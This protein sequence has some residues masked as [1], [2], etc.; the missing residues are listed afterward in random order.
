MA[1][2]IK[3][4]ARRADVSIAT[5]SM[6]MNDTPG[7]SEKT[8]ERVRNIIK[9][10]NYIPN[11]RARSISIGRAG[12]IALITPPWKAA[13]SDPYYTEMIRGALEAARAKENQ[14]ML[15]ICDSHFLEQKLWKKLF[16]SKKIDGMLVATPYL[17]QDYIKELHD[18]GKPVLLINGERPD[19]PDMQSIGYDDF[20]CGLEATNYLLQLGHCRIA[21]ISGPA[22]Q[23]SAINRKEGYKKALTNAGLPVL[24]DYIVDGNYMPLEA[25]DAIIKLLSLDKDKIPTAIFCANDTM[26][27]SVITY[28]TEQGYSVPLDFSVIGVDDNS[29]ASE[30]QPGLT[31]FKQD[32]FSLAYNVTTRFLD[33]FDNK[34]PADRISMRIPMEMVIR[35]SCARYQTL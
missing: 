7:I 2:S 16:D 17:D 20:R 8:R 11:A 1:V 33:N 3:D 29:I 23:A 15:E 34:S 19:L 5:V 32:I 18:L 4:I 26:G 10:M 22:N 24:D 14:L 25:R 35:E 21:H 31:T 9:E 13:F 28:L 27:A 30:I 12:I 6:V